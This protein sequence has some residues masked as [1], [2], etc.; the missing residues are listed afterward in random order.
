[1]RRSPEN[2]KGGEAA[3]R[4]ELEAGS[5]T[6]GSREKIEADLEQRRREG[7]RPAAKDLH[8]PGPWQR[9][10]P[11]SGFAAQDRARGR[12]LARQAYLYSIA[13]WAAMY[14]TRSMTPFG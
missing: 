5:G 7:G 14:W 2:S 3:T 1:V 9:R 4:R 8:R 10:Q 12:L 13:I 6:P 11:S